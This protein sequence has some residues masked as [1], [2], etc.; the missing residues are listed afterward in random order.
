MCVKNL[1]YFLY[2]SLDFLYDKLYYIDIY[3]ISACRDKY[4]KMEYPMRCL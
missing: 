2:D 4:L 3:N 1:L